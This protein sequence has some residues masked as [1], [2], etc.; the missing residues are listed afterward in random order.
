MKSILVVTL[1]LAV[2]SP[3]LTYAQESAVTPGELRQAMVAAAASR[4][5]D[6]DTVQTF[7]SSDPARK[8][9]KAGGIDPERVQ[10]AVSTL[11]AD[12]LANLAARTRKIQ[13][14]FAAGAL[15]NEQLTY[16]VIAIG[17]ALIVI[18]ILAL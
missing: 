3:Q 17:T 2:V 16:I 10:R 1:V 13:N 12:E 7:F 5:R 14:D 8:A 4:G 11:S 6:L 18:L 15:N 9:L